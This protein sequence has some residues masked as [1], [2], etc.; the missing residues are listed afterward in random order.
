[1]KKLIPFFLI[2]LL[3]GGVFFI[4]NQKKPTVKTNDLKPNNTQKTE[5]KQATNFLEQA[6]KNNIGV[7]CTYED[8]EKNQIITYIKGKQILTKIS[9]KSQEPNNF[10]YKNNLTYMWN[11]KTKA[12][13]I[14][15]IEE[16]KQDVKNT[17]NPVKNQ[18]QVINEISKYK[19]ECVKENLVDNFFQPPKGINF[20]DLTQ[21]QQ[22]A[23]QVQDMS[24]EE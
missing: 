10:L 6:L 11:D 18:N 17:E 7:K 20:Q 21:L 16:I 13:M 3:V 5:E 12:G 2:L 19:Y 1:M 4:F 23:P 15:K 24:V 9:N 22:M 8:P 14:I